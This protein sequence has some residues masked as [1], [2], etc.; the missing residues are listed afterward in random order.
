MDFERMWDKALRNT[1][2]VRSRV[3]SLKTN[4]ETQVPYVL[5]SE[6]SIN[7]G[8]TIVRKGQVVVEKPSIIM[9]PYQP[10]LNG[11]E[12]GEESHFNKDTLINFLLVRGISL[13]SLKYDNIT[14][15]LDIRE[16]KLSLAIKHYQEDLQKKEDVHSGLI[17]GPE[18]CW[19]LSLLIFICA[20]I[21]KN[22][23]SDIRK[24]LEEFHRKDKH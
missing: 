3:Q 6:S 23:E 10:L 14:N 17:I 19:Q 21:S 4:M 15:S 20:Q 8:D 22:A 12:F 11:F 1:E 16:G 18:D 9:P 13:P 7:V 5:L 2:I 24:L